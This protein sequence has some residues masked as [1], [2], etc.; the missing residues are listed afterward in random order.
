LC[1]SVRRVPPAKASSSNRVSLYSSTLGR[2][3]ASRV[4]RSAWVL[5][6]R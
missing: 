5:P 4:F 3:L 6:P 2:R 1:H